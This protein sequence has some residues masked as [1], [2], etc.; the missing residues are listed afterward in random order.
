MLRYILA[1]GCLNCSWDLG[2][3]AS[4]PCWLRWRYQWE[5]GENA[6][7]VNHPGYLISYF[8]FKVADEIP[9]SPFDIFVSIKKQGFVMLLLLRSWGSHLWHAFILY[10]VERPSYRIMNTTVQVWYCVQVWDLDVCLQCLINLLK[11]SQLENL[12]WYYMMTIL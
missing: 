2:M 9:G 10:L 11:A 6:S 12:E 8:S 5:V 4:G 7:S 1:F 3:P